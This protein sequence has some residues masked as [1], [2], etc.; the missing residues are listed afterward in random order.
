MCGKLVSV[1]ENNPLKEYI[2]FCED[3]LTLNTENSIINNLKC[4]GTFNIKILTFARYLSR[5]KRLEKV[6]SKEG[7]AMVIR[8]IIFENTSKLLY[9]GSNIAKNTAQLVY[10]LI[11][12][13]K[14]AKVTPS[15]LKNFNGS[16][17]ILK[18]KLSDIIYIYEKYNE[19]LN[20]GYYDES[21]YLELLPQII[22]NDENLNGAQIFL[23][24]FSSFT[25][26][27]AAV[28]ESLIRKCE[29]VC[30][31]FCGGTNEIYTN[32]AGGV[33]LRICTELGISPEI[34]KSS[35]F[36]KKEAEIILN[37]LF[38][39]MVFKK[40]ADTETDSIFIYE[41]ADATDE[42]K[43][44]CERII[45]E[46]TENNLRYRDIGILA[47]T[48]SEMSLKKY[49]SEYNIPYFLDDR[50]NLT[51]HPLSRLLNDYLKI[52]INDYSVSDCLSFIK[53]I[54]FCED[55]N[56][57]DTFEN[58]I[59][60]Y[61][62]YRGFIKKEL[63]IIDENAL[64]Y[65]NLRK[66]AADLI[67][68][69]KKMTALEFCESL[70]NLMVSINA[71]NKIKELGLTLKSLNEQSAAFNE[72]IYDN[73]NAIIDEIAII[74]PDVI[75][76]AEEFLNILSSGMLAKKISL[77]P[78]YNDSVFIG[79]YDTKPINY[80]ILFCL[81]LNS[82]IPLQ[83][84]D[85]AFISDRDII[86]LKNFDVVIEPKIE[87]VNLRQREIS[88]IG[89]SSFNEKLFLSYSLIDN[90]GKEQRKSEIITYIKKMFKQGGSELNVINRSFLDS[91]NDNMNLYTIYRYS[92]PYP[93]LINFIT[94]A[95]LF[96]DGNKTE[97]VAA[98]SFY[99]AAD[100]DLKAEADRLLKLTDTAVVKQIDCGKNLFVKNGYLSTTLLQGYFECPYKNFLR[101]GLKIKEREL[102]S[103]KPNDS[104]NFLHEIMD[105]AFGYMK[106]LTDKQK[107]DLFCINQTEKLLQKE[108]YLTMKKNPASYQSLL[109]LSKE[110]ARIIA[111]IKQHNE[112]TDFKPLA[113][114]IKFGYEGS[115]YPPLALDTG[116]EKLKLYGII[117]RLDVS[118][119]YMRIIDYKSGKV[120]SKDLSADYYAGKKLQLWLYLNAVRMDLL[121]AAV[122]IL[123]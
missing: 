95:L 83:K 48:T 60:R 38:D 50:K 23:T 78:S 58:Y 53:N 12:Q 111:A 101:L 70:K 10:E 105:I 100:S 49:L 107:I 24:G 36:L 33:F 86:K 79:G 119:N 2:V 64:N 14:S 71:E 69:T 13:L 22:E 91:V 51:E 9:L 43:F 44:M 110:A 67:K 122:I 55:K 56:L 96:K 35:I 4:N 108:P 25:R 41:A 30:G 29:R 104:G 54:F 3:K 52:V 77:I 15:L 73:L 89:I 8:R 112:V 106:D 39:P 19:F 120:D 76:E 118:E 75:L 85:T 63:Y 66:K 115:E 7:A 121:P 92:S 20:S 16:D 81:N 27:A 28:V 102:S 62:N 97:L 93:A 68:I 98:A 26:Q 94:D 72:Q 65:E 11:A 17:A 47:D 80:K 59:L 42:I 113:R 84:A 116:K 32:E 5:K 37:N 46:I 61:N 82:A 90:K 87:L 74:M 114:E 109:R 6:L 117:D 1:A 57:S 31:I 34:I 21:S 123:I 88:G 40:N 45:Y 18:N 99:A 103:V